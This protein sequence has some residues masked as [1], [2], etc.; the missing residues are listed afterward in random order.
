MEE[1]SAAIASLY[2]D[3]DKCTQYGEA[4][5]VKAETL[6]SREQIYQY[7]IEIYKKAKENSQL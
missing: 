7:L 4:G 1:L 5:R 3:V 6:Y 2:P